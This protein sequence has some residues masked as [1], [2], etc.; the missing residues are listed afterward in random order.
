M[1]LRVYRGELFGVHRYRIGIRAAHEL[2]FS[3]LKAVIPRT[4]LH[5]SNTPPNGRCTLLMWSICCHIPN[6]MEW[7]PSYSKIYR[8]RYNR[9]VE[10]SMRFCICFEVHMMISNN[11][12]SDSIGLV[13]DGCCSRS[14]YLLSHSTQITIVVFKACCCWCVVEYI[15]LPGAFCLLKSNFSH[16]YRL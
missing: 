15:C 3:G 8:H 10:D 16:W 1:V 13:N 4:R 14:F 5:T 6:K 9:G 11:S 7:R 12:C 2:L